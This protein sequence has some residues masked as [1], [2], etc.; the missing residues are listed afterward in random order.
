MNKNYRD[1]GWHFPPTNGGRVDGFND[2]G[3][4]TFQGAPR[5]LA[6]REKRYK[7]RLMPGRPPINPCTCHSK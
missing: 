3:H 7:T 6:L 4:S 5:T 1:I 2:P